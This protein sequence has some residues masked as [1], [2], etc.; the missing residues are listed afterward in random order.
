MDTRKYPDN[1]GT[2]DRRS[3]KRIQRHPVY[4][5]VAS[6]NR[7]L[8]AKYETARREMHAAETKLVDATAEVA[9]LRRKLDE[10]ESKLSTATG[11]VEDL[12]TKLA[13]AEQKKAS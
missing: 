2:L 7:E 8:V 6:R 11:I 5:G 12:K 4:Q 13:D 3:V 1:G 10:T 9:R